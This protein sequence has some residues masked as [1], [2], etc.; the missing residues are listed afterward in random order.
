MHQ[1]SGEYLTRRSLAKKPL[2]RCDRLLWN[3]SVEQ[4][5]ATFG[6]DDPDLT[7]FR[8]R[9]GKLIIT[10]GLADQLIPPQG[11]IDYYQRVQRQMG[12]RNA[13]RSLRGSS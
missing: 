6:S 2:A 4:Y 13:R 3:Q 7:R 1:T 8:A 12:A 10:H 11:T 5:G 9:G